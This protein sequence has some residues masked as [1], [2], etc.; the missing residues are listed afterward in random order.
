MTPGR[1]L[2]IILFSGFLF[3]S[4]A[5]AGGSPSDENTMMP[6]GGAGISSLHTLG[7]MTGPDNGVTGGW[8][9]LAPLPEPRVA[10]AAASAGDYLYVIGGAGDLGANLTTNTT[11]RY[12]ITGNTWDVMA[13]MPARLTGIGAAVAGTRIYV[14]GSRSDS[15]TYVYDIPGNSWSSIPASFGFTGRS[16]ACVVASGPYIVVLGGSNIGADALAEIWRL[17]PETGVW[18]QEVNLPDARKA[19]ATSTFGRKAV[20]TGGFNSTITTPYL[21]TWIYDQTSWKARKAVPDNG[22]NYTRWSDMAF[23]QTPTGDLWI[24]GGA[25]DDAYRVL[26]HTG[27]YYPGNDTWKATPVLPVLSQPRLN[28]AGTVAPDG[29]FY[30]AGG[31]DGEDNILSTLER[32]QVTLPVTSVTPKTGKQGTLVKV[33]NLAGNHFV[34]GAKVSLTR[35]S[36]KIS[37]RAVNV[38]DPTRITCKITIPATAPA[39]KWDVRVTNP[40]GVSGI[41]ATGFTVKKA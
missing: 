12:N 30:V 10:A 2:L 11:F 7:G 5:P 22:G 18:T 15:T 29:Y 40:G 6:V 33:K 19:F 41:L 20:V 36:K 16:Q 1:V 31:R 32:L 34:T 9:T 28:A 26:N 37:A 27:V 14:P 23:G 4:G 8:E 3:C 13:P 35:G 17:D 25:R 39:G 24:A 38:A 21:T